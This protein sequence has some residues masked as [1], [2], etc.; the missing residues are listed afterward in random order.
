[1]MVRLVAEVDITLI[2]E[3]DITLMM[4]VEAEMLMALPPIAPVPVADPGGAGDTTTTTVDPVDP[5]THSKAMPPIPN[6]VPSGLPGPSLG[7]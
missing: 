7:S 3:V 5:N 1:M 6:P 4:E 2:M